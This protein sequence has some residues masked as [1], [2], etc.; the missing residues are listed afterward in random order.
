M[1]NSRLIVDFETLRKNYQL[2]VQRLGP[3]VQIMP[4]VKGNG[5]GIGAFEMARFYESLGVPFVGTSYAEEAV[6]LRE[7]GYTSPIFVLSC[8]DAK[9]AFDFDLTVALNAKEQVT[10]LHCEGKRRKKCLPVHLQLD[11]GL[12]RLGFFPTQAQKLIAEIQK[13]P[14]LHLEGVMSHFRSQEKEQAE[15]F[16]Q[17]L[18]YLPKMRWIHMESSNSVFLNLIPPA[19]LVRLG[20]LLFGTPNF[21]ACALTLETRVVAIRKCHLGEKLGYLGRTILERNT[22]LATLGIGYH[23]GINLASSAK[24]YVKIHGQKAPYIG[25]IYMDFM[26]V[27]IT[28]IPNVQV[29]NRAEIFG[30]ELLIDEVASWSNTNKRQLLS[31]IGPRVKRDYVRQSVG[32]L[33]TSCTS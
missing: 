10:A 16:L 8:L 24:G 20:A 6:F 33:E 4:M 27:D 11:T 1:P 25:N 14:W 30:P 17:F 31:C 13:S 28:D 26:M 22:T 9:M 23:D 7:A 21:G 12:N 15:V 5:Y 29:G 18:P 2:I 19:N 32:T 3:H